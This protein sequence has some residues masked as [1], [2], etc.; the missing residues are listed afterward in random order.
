MSDR[1]PSRAKVLRVLRAGKISNF[2][3]RYGPDEYGL[4]RPKGRPVTL[5]HA[6]KLAQIDK[7][8]EEL[9]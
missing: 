4:H 9:Q 7:R 5:P 8:L 3:T 1:K 6:D 2:N